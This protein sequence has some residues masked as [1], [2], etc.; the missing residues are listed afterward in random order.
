MNKSQ[1]RINRVQGCIAVKKIKRIVL[2][3]SK[4]ATFIKYIK[5]C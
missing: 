3:I 4:Q 2:M 1:T 5:K